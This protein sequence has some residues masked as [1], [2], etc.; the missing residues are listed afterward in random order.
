MCQKIT[1]KKVS[2]YCNVLKDEKEEGNLN[3]Q[4]DTLGYIMQFAYTYHVEREL[5]ESL[6]GMI[7]N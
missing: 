6:S 3:P 1:P 5:P 2:D 7:L 4:Q